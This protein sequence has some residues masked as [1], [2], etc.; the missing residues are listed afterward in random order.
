MKTRKINIKFNNAKELIKL[1]IDSDV[2]VNWGSEIKIANKLLSQF[3]EIEFWRGFALGVVKFDSL[4]I[5][6][7]KIH[8]DRL[9]KEYQSFLAVKTLIILLNL[10]LNKILSVCVHTPAT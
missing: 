1:Y 2:K 9:K 3:P 6:L 8:N 5:F 4:C 10:I 7:N